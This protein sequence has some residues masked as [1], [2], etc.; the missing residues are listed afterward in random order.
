MARKISDGPI[1]S[2]ERSMQKVLDAVG[3]ILR[4]EGYS[5]L[6]INHISEVAKIDKTSIYRYFGSTKDLIDTYMNKEDYWMDKVAPK[7]KS[8][9]EESSQFG[10]DEIISILHTMLDEVEKSRDLQKILL[11]ELSEYQ[12]RLRELADNR[13][14]LG[15][16]LF[17][18]TDRDFEGTDVN[19]RSII[20]LQIAGIYYLVLHAKSNATT[21]CEIDVNTR[22]GMDTIR[23]ALT[24]IMNWA[25]S[26]S[27]Q[28]S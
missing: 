22:E 10:K 4:T 13:E 9:V 11:W 15:S 24:K 6:K 5:A 18:L 12:E 19:L 8:I 1:N 25:Y 7:V 27:K 21:F 28:N 16:G 26:E 3:Q 14:K 20:A 17:K 23:K 2:R